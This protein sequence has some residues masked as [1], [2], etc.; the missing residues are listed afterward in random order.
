[1]VSIITMSTMNAEHAQIHT[2]LIA[3]IRASTNTLKMV[4]AK[5]VL[6]Q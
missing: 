1:M 2:V 4:F 3:K 5:D 6:L